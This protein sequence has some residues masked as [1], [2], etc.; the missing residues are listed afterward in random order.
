MATYSGA[1][2]AADARTRAWR[3]LFQ[4]LIVDVLLAVVAALALVL[5]DPA[6][7]WSLAYWGAVGLSLGK[8]ALTAVTAYIMR[9]A[10]PPAS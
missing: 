10:A 1:Q 5:A 3:T 6:F 9:Q 4:G 2:A 8:T 7:E